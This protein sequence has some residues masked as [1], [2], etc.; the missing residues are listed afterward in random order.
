MHLPAK[1]YHQLNVNVKRKTK[2]Q[3]WD[4]RLSIRIQIMYEKT[5]SFSAELII[6]LQAGFA[7]RRMQS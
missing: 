1:F 2:G 3:L 6:K 5:S 4:A 7:A